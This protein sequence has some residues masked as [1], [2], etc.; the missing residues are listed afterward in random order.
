LSALLADAERAHIAGWTGIAAR[1]SERAA[2]ADFAALA[3]SAIEIVGAKG[4][5]RIV[6]T[7]NSRRAGIQS[8][9]DV[10]VAVSRADADARA[11]EIGRGAAVDVLAGAGAWKMLANEPRGARQRVGRALV[12]VVA[13]D[14]G[15]GARAGPGVAK[16]LSAWIGI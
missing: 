11:A 9:V 1:G 5:L 16:I 10:V 13:V 4:I 8:A 2:A 15:I 7:T 12:A 6:C 3:D 14:R